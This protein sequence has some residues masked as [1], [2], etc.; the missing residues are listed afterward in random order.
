MKH[1]IGNILIV[2]TS[3]CLALVLCEVGLWFLGI[4]YPKFWEFDPILGSKL[5]PGSQGY[6]LQEGGGYVTINSDGLRDREHGLDKPPN[7]LRIAVLGDSYTEAFQV[8]RE[9]AFWAVMEKD[10]NECKNLGHRQVEVLNFG[11]SGFGTTLELLALRHRGWKYSPDVVLLAFVYND[12]IDNFKPLANQLG[13][14]LYEYVPY[15]FYQEGKLIL[16]DR[17]KEFGKKT[18][19]LSIMKSTWFPFQEWLSNSRIF[20]LAKH[21]Q[22]IVWSNSK[23]DPFSYVH[24][25]KYRQPTDEL[26]KEAWRVTEGVLLMMRDEVMQRGVKFFVV[27]LTDPN[28]V[29]PDPVVRHKYAKSIGVE[30]LFYPNRRLEKFCQREG[31][32]ILLLAPTFQKYADKHQVYFHGFKNTLGFGGNLGFGHW[33]QAGHQLAGNLIA[34]W[35]CEQIN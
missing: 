24:D 22:N 28:Q 23:V 34:K 29:H 16:V 19:K 33:N 31:I 11:Q 25:A 7:T 12:L 35:L 3:L 21:C 2:L 26:W 9:D 6:W 17:V 13:N 1:R 5:R 18:K 32:P 8:N 4:E 14:P 30:N 20:L 27:V 15:Y 10:L